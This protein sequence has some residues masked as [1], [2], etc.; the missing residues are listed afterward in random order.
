MS[1]MFSYGFGIRLPNNEAKKNGEIISP[2]ENKEH[3]GFQEKSITITKD[4]FA[5]RAAKVVGSG[6]F[7]QMSMEKDPMMGA[8]NMMM[9]SILVSEIMLELFG[10][11]DE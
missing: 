2:E 1:D 6:K 4:E 3:K 5:R 11:E 10:E 8:L 7:A 9:G